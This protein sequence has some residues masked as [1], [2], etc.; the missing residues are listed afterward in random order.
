MSR[1]SG[2]IAA[3]DAFARGE[4]SAEAATTAALSRLNSIAG[5][6]AL[7]TLT[8]DAAQEQA[9]AQ[10]AARAKGRPLGPLAGVP[11]AHKD[12]FYRTGRTSHCGST[13]ASG[14][15]GTTTASVLTR[16][17]GAGAI[18]LGTLHMAEFALSPTGY[19]EHYGHGRNPWNPDH[20]CGGSSS[21]SGI[22]VAARAIAGSLG[23]DTGGSLRHPAAACGL[24]GLKPTHGAVS[25]AGAM[26]LSATLDTVGPLTTSARDAARI[27]DVIA[28]EDRA[29][30]TTA[31][32]P[33]LHHE[34]ALTG[35]IAGLTLARPRGYYDEELDSVIAS[36]LNDAAAT[37]TGLGAT[38]VE[39]TAPEM[40]PANAFAHLVMAVEAATLHREWLIT[41]PQDYADQVRARIEPGLCYRATDYAGAL[42]RRGAIAQNW[43]D[44]VMGGADA[45]LLPAYPVP[46]P[47]IA[48]TTQGAP[49]DI[50]RAIATLTRNTRAINYLGL[51]AIAFPIGF[52]RAG[53][54]IACQIVG[55]PWCEPL[56]L[57]LADAFQQASDFHLRQPESVAP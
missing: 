54:P 9:R 52:D 42:M 32:A 24:T 19:N 20:I 39:T 44:T 36:A 33:V 17:D 15:V 7:A 3:A 18:D 35:K 51:P 48:A 21:G 34:A 29:D 2:V 56:L 40:A 23:T 8:P 55:R 26:A 11:M 49:Q 45:A 46:V 28:G 27:M 4:I 53:L 1:C 14:V 43:I 31:W 38:L 13:I 5:L 12:L 16:L 37:L 57:R 10:D 25:C 30:P 50:A 47:S 41:R 6:N 22:A